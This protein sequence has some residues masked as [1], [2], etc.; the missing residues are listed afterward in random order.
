MWQKTWLLTA[1][2]FYYLSD[3]MMGGGLI[4]YFL[5]CKRLNCKKDVLAQQKGAHLLTANSGQDFVGT[6]QLYHYHVEKGGVW[7]E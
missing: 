7:G 5:D 1:V 3:S 2:E 6:Y 4:F